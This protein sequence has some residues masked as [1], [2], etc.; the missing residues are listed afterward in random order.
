MDYFVIAD[1]NTVK[2]FSLLGLRSKECNT[3]EDVIN[4]IN[5][6]DKDKF[7]IIL[8]THNLLQLVKDQIYDYKNLVQIVELNDDESLDSIARKTIGLNN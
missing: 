5:F 8:I 6:L 1:K 4:T 3:K 7:F 2:G